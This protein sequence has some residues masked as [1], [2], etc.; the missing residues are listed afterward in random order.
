MSSVCFQEQYETTVRS[1]QQKWHQCN[2]FAV[3]R[4]ILCI[5]IFVFLL[6]GYFWQNICYSFS[7]ICLMIFLFVVHIHSRYKKEY[8][9][10]KALAGIYLKHIHRIQGQWKNFEENGEQFLDDKNFQSTDLDI[11]GK[12]S[13]YQMICI[14]KSEKGK[15]RLAKWLI[16]DA[17]IHDV[18]E[19]QKAVEELS[20]MPDF[21]I[22]M[23]TWG[24][25]LTSRKSQNIEKWLTSLSESSLRKVPIILFILPCVT[26]LSLLM[27]CFQLVMPY[28][29]AVLEIGIVLQLVLSFAFFFKH[30]QMFEPVAYLSTILKSYAH[31][32]AHISQQHFTS[33]YLCRLQECLCQNQD[34][35]KAIMQ[36]SQ[37]SQKI[38]YR[39]NLLA[40]LLL[41]GLGLF[42]FYLR[43]HYVRWLLQ[44]RFSVAQWFE[45]LA[46][47]E[48]LMS[49]T[50]L[51]IDDFDVNMPLLSQEKTLSFTQLRH[52]LIAPDQVIGNDFSMQDS[53]C[54]ITGSNMSGKT[55]FMRTIALN[56][57]LA[58][59]GGF[60]F[61]K[62]LHCSCMHIMT[63]MRVKDNVEEGISTFY[64]EL[65]RIKAMIDYSQ[66]GLPMIC[67]IDEIFKG[68]NSLDRIAGAQAT[69]KKL[70]LPY[71]YTFLTTHDLELGE[72]TTN[73][74][75]F[76]E[77]YK[78]NQ[79]YF[80]Y[81]I[82]KGISRSSNGQFLLKQ[83]GIIDE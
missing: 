39:Q 36:L 29:L 35:V 11:F 16:D 2:M 77:Y 18:I 66:K 57:V 8:S 61:A 15:A 71:A 81:H 73:N 52:P 65:L 14:A 78:D 41:N 54:I 50:V 13:L 28:S 44:Y 38:S 72:L 20:Q 82:K 48:A 25:W 1:C 9:Y 6:M 62:T 79:I 37:L 19:R 63:S 3:L 43:Y 31:S 64:G 23:E 76:D 5:M 49:L 67:F 34:A 45:C 21:I 12:N 10:Q 55:T 68:T 53:L 80:D 33:D 24:T 7:P 58:Y 46:D 75:H 59:A 40:F 4:L 47:L 42:D 30:Q 51:K 60:V 22:Q 56:L 70:S 17:D 69:I 74:Y 27:V 83:L 26:C 32:Y